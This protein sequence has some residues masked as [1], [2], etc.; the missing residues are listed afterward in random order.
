[1]AALPMGNMLR[2][3]I[4]ELRNLDF[5]P[6][7]ANGI[8]LFKPVRLLSILSASLNC[9]VSFHIHSF[10]NNQRMEIR[11][12]AISLRLFSA[13]NAEFL[14]LYKMLGFSQGHIFFQM[15]SRITI[16]TWR[17]RSQSSPI[18][19]QHEICY[20]LFCRPF[21]HPGRWNRPPLSTLNSRQDLPA[22]PAREPPGRQRARRT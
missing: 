3:W 13:F 8:D 12:M 15:G 7:L 5:R 16:A 14:C 20:S 4:Y 22:L 21:R 10:M 9:T 19:F 18:V 11:L 2:Q 6:G 17:D 1:M